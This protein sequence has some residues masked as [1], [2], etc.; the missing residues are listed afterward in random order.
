MPSSGRVQRTRFNVRWTPAP[1]SVAE[2][3]AES[4]MQ[5]MAIGLFPS[6]TEAS[7]G[8]DN[9]S[10]AEFGPSM[11]SLVMKRPEDVDALADASGPLNKLSPDQLAD[12]LRRFGLAEEDARGY[13]DAVLHLSLL[14]GD[15][16][17]AHL[18]VE[19][20]LYPILLVVTRARLRRLRP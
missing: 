18:L 1:L 5:P 15:G 14:K 8:L 12:R 9:L 4:T 2:R 19:I 10:E 13:R 3:R 16:T 11:I 7:L 17:R 20:V 6:P